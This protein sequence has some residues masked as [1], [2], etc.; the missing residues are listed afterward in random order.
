[1]TLTDHEIADA[2]ASG[3]LVLNAAKE[4]IGPACYEL[5]M[6]TV[7]YDLTE[8]DHRVEVN[9]GRKVLIKPGHRVV[10]I[11]LEQLIVPPDIIA[12]V[13]SKGSLFSIGLS[14]VCTYADPG[15]EGNLGIVTQNISDKYIELPVGEPIAKVDFSRLT[16]DV[17]RPY[18]GQH[19]FQVQIWPIKHHLQRN[20]GEVN[21][22][23]RV[24]SEKTEAYRLLPAATAR[25]LQRME[26]RQ[27]TV[28]V[29]ILLAVIVNAVILAVISTKLIG[30]TIGIVSNLIASAIVA[31]VVIL[32]RKEG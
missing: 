1:M 4:R 29:A 24:A 15:F 26:R 20:Y 10:L 31:A 32:S 28:D 25:L 8:E 23:P 21:H 27:K 22:D 9:D 3:N 11:T 5:R 6:G 14:A 16:K 2:I 30:T 17:D 7:Y 18:R 13:V 12:R 19:G